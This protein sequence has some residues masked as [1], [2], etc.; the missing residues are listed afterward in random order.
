MI[1]LF[2]LHSVRWD[3]NRTVVFFTGDIWSVGGQYTFLAGQDFLGK[4]V[5]ETHFPGRQI[6]SDAVK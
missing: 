6:S 5:L 1:L 2:L 3:R 4:V